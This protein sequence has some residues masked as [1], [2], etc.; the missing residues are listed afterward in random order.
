MNKQDE[1][2]DEGQDEEEMMKEN[3]GEH[4]VMKEKRS[5]GKSGKARHD[6][7]T[8]NEQEDWGKGEGTGDSKQ[9]TR[10]RQKLMKIN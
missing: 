9:S 7:Q 4:I 5:K 8:R 1:G 6:G 10:T 3:G 2:Q